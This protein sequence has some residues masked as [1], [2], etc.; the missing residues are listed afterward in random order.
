MY[1]RHVPVIHLDSNGL[2]WI[3]LQKLVLDTAMPKY[4]IF[5]FKKLKE[6]N[7]PSFAMRTR[8]LQ[9][10]FRKRNLTESWLSVIFQDP[11][12]PTIPCG[13]LTS[14]HN[15]MSLYATFTRLTLELRGSPSMFD[16]WLKKMVSALAPDSRA[17]VMSLRPS[18]MILPLCSRYFLDL[19]SIVAR[20]STW[21][22]SYKFCLNFKT[23]FFNKI[24]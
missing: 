16:T 12:S 4:I 22:Q 10:Y 14:D 6:I 8:S 9:E 24:Q 3:P 23:F 15:E 19:A 11:Y 18:R 7:T 21:E 13:V 5:N 17:S 2:L 20:L 1:H